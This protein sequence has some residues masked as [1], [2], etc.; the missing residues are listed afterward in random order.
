[1]RIS[2]RSFLYQVPDIL[3]AIM[4][5]TFRLF[6]VPL[7]GHAFSLVSRSKFV[8]E[9]AGSREEYSPAIIP[10]QLNNRIADYI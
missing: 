3:H 6:A 4:G 10:K 2:I 8:P 5:V 1:M 9:R 7:S